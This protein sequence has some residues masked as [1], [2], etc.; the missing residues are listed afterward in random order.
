MAGIDLNR[1]SAGVA[2]LLPR[3]ISQEIWSNA[4]SNS[5]VMQASRQI[6]LPGGGITIPI[7]TGEPVADWVNETDEKPVSRS[8]VSSKNMTGY[9]MAVIEPF[10]NQFRRDLPGLYS[11]LARRLPFALGRKFDQTVLGTTAPGADFDTLGDAATVEVAGDDVVE[12][13]ATVL[14]NVGTAGGDLSHWLISPQLEGAVRLAKDP[15]TGSYAFLQD[16]RT[17]G[18]SIGSIFGRPVLKSNGVYAPGT[19]PVLGIAGDF[20]NSA[21]YGVVE[22]IN[23]SISD[24]ATIND[25]GT[26]LNLWQRNMFA[27]RAEFEVGFIVRD[28]THFN[29]LTGAAV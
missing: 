29:K 21:I 7:I 19:P 13:L 11:E 5:I 16:A 20:S 26:Q 10:S 6:A 23:V 3:E 8:T 2:D 15:G 12:D 1:T 18:G 27:L 14:Q 28:K 25:G 17:D 9:T 24:Q 4:V 22:N